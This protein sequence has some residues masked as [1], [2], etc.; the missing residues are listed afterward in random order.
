MT[1]DHGAARII[2]NRAAREFL[3]VEPQAEA[4]LSLSA[5]PSE[6]PAHFRVMKDGREL[7]P[8]ELPVQRAMNEGVAVNNEELEIVFDDGTIKYELISAAPLLGVEGR[9]RG[10]VASLMD[11]TERRLAEREREAM[12]VR[13]QATRVEAEAAN[14][15]K[16]EF[17]ATVS[18][19]LRTP[20]NAMLGWATLL[21]GRIPDESMIDDALETIERNCR[22]QAQLIEDLLDVSRINAGNLRLD[23]KP[24][25]LAS[26]LTAALEA[27]Q[28]AAHAKSILIEMSPRSTSTSVLGDATRIQQV[29]WNLLSNAVKFTP[30]GGHVV[31]A[32]DTTESEALIT[33]QDTGEGISADFLPYVFDRFRQ[34]DGTKTRR[35]GGLGLGLAIARHLVEAHGG[36]IE[37]ASEGVGKGATFTVRLP[38][39]SHELPARLAADKPIQRTD[40]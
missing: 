7:N 13:E 37:A 35:H 30:R 6:A 23:V 22:L 24:V 39:L 38:L 33:V 40:A 10:A 31:I 1:L 34:A 14:R 5:P 12:L 11:I 25:E 28:H 36:T 17:L 20:L 2:G 21:R 29:V 32:V 27:V 3:R 15:A 16:D 9:P 26:V 19:E 4:N 8:D 18:H